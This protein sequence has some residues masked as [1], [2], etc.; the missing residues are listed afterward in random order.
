MIKTDNRPL[1]E[2]PD[3]LNSVGVDITPN[4]FLST[5]IDRLMSCVVVSNTIIGRPVVSIDGFGIRSGVLMD[6]VMKRLPVS[7]ANNLK[8]ERTASFHSTHDNRL[9]TL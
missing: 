7:F 3:I 9:I 8:P 1:K 5:M 4:P 6:K 2:A